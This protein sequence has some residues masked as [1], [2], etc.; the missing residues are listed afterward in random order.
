MIPSEFKYCIN[1]IRKI[2][3]DKSKSEQTMFEDIYEIIKQREC[4]RGC[5]RLERGG[6]KLGAHLCQICFEGDNYV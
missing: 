5:G 6:N 2:I 1:I 4:I 3:N